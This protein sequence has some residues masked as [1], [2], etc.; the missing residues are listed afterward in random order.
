MFANNV[1]GGK[2]GICKQTASVRRHLSNLFCC[3][4]GRIWFPSPWFRRRRRTAS[5]GR[6]TWTARPWKPERLAVMLTEPSLNHREVR[7][8]PPQVSNASCYKSSVKETRG[9]IF[10]LSC[11]TAIKK[12]NICGHLI[13][14]PQLLDPKQAALTSA[15]ETGLP[16]LT[17][18]SSSSQGLC[19]CPITAPYWLLNTGVWRLFYPC[20]ISPPRVYTEQLQL[21]PAGWIS[22][23]AGVSWIP[24]SQSGF[25]RKISCLCVFV[26]IYLCIKSEIWL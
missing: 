25:L 12:K 8:P 1:V 18:S 24:R 15:A 26:Y 3:N 11:Q 23:E 10:M 17:S 9:T 16:E 4:E 5:A 6:R 2:W 7:K 19:S 13:Y 21:F 22:T 20:G 14:K